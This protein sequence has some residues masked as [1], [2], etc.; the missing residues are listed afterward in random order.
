MKRSEKD[1]ELQSR[2]DFFKKAAQKALPILG[3]IIIASTP[4]LS[5]AANHESETEYGCD[6]GC[7]GWWLWS[8]MFLWMLKQ[9]FWHVF[10]RLQRVMYAKLQWLMCIRMQ[11][12]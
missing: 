10:W 9:L 6:W 4:L 7:S 5:Q 1:E 12:W 2:R 11:K 8:F 3:G